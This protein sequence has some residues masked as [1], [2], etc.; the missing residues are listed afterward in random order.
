M[1]NIPKFPIGNKNDLRL[2]WEIGSLEKISRKMWSNRYN[3]SFSWIDWYAL[4]ED[5]AELYTQTSQAQATI[6]RLVDRLKA[7]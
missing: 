2:F 1:R 6:K 4:E 5:I 7:N 3:K